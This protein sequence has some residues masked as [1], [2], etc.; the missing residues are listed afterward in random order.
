[1]SRIPHRRAALGST[2]LAAVALILGLSVGVV[3]AAGPGRTATLWAGS[4]DACSGALTTSVGVGS[5][6]FSVHA[7][8]NRARVTVVGAT[9]STTYVIWQAWTVGSSCNTASIGSL[10][11]DSQGNG[12]LRFGWFLPADATGFN[13]AVASNSEMLATVEL[14]R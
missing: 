4:Y 9:A 14:T 1:M 5:V 2:A 7:T 3:D 13:F 12:S 6:D 11:T 10:V 8:R